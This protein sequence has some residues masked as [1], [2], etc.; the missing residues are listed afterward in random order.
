MVVSFFGHKD[1]PSTVKPFLEQTVQRLIEENEDITFLVGTHGA[2]DLMAQSVLK[3]ALKRYP[4]IICYIVL[5]Y[6]P[7][8]DS[9]ERYISPTLVPEGIE[10]V[11]K[12]FAITFRNNYMVKECD[13][14]ICYITH[15]WGGAWEFV[16]KARQKGKNIINLAQYG[17]C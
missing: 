8:G 4:R 9:S 10:S 1:T 15:D 13:T 7:V 14:V 17:F 11:P 2:F 16:H 6:V 12:R 3:Q 5:A